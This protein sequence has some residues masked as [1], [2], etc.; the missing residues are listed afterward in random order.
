[1]S[2]VGERFIFVGG[3]PR[4]GTTLVQNML[5]CHPDIWGGPEFLH[6]PDITNLR[7]K[8]VD[9]VAR[10]WIDAYVSRERVDELVRGMVEAMLL[11]AAD[12]T[13]K[14]FLSEKSP[15]NVLAFSALIELFPSAHFVHVVRD[16]RAV[17]AS[18]LQVGARAKEKGVKSAAYTYTCFAAIDYTR[19]CLEAGF[20]A[21]RLAPDRIHTVVYEQLV[22]DPDKTSRAL[23]AYIGIDWVEQMLRPGEV[24]HAGEKA[25]TQASGEVWYDKASYQRNIDTRGLSDWSQ[26]LTA[27]QQHEVTTAFAGNADLEALGY[28]FDT[29]SLPTVDAATRAALMGAR[30][31]RAARRRVKRI[32]R[33]PN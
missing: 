6:L 23:C 1:M 7:G 11:P 31:A 25:I 4:S 28:R 27:A 16:P 17:V 32:L 9:S 30:V 12:R 18:L 3:A 19:K 14:R 29:A 5:D 8:L 26:K 20:A 24:E 13:G 10:G 2:T 22:Q 15:Q 33:G 21:T